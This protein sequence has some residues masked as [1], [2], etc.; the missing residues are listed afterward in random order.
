MVTDE[1]GEPVLVANAEEASASAGF[2]VRLPAEAASSKIYVTDSSAFTLT[3]NRDKAQAFIESAGRS[4]LVLPETIDGAEIAVSIPSTVSAAFGTCPE[5]QMEKREMGEM[6]GPRESYPDCIVFSQMTSPL[7]NAPD[8][9]DMAQLAQIGL[10]FSGMS[11]AEAAAFT[12]TIDWTSTLVIPIPRNAATY[13]DV[14]V[15]GVTGKLIMRES[16]YSPE[17][18][19]LWV[20]DG[21]R[22]RHQRIGHRHRPRFCNRGCFEINLSCRCEGASPKQP[23]NMRRLLTA[24]AYGAS[25]VGESALLA[26]TCGYKISS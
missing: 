5:P 3:V 26:M 19:L 7:V 4:D 24:L 21:D 2:N 12:S 8:G 11:R 23:S 13:E 25:V 17:Y 15:D 16:N 6:D 9:V 1:P 14:S 20:K 10:E 18:A 22:V